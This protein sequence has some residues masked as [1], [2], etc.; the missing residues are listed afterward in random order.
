MKCALHE[1]EAVAVCVHCGRALCPDCAQP[2]ANQRMVCSPTCAA[3]LARHDR[4][5]QLIL[6]KGYQNARA[7][8]FYCYLCGALSAGGAVGANYYLP[9]PFLIWFTAGC[10][11]VFIAS[12]IWYGRI[13]RQQSL[14]A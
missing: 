6:Q 13:A 8:S 10:A 3:A 12:G 14:D 1:A 11:L 9:M 2:T 7:S 5:L 4:A